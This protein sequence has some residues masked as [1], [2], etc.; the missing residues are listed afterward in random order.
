MRGTQIV[1][2]ECF[3][4]RKAQPR[5]REG[6]LRVP[7]HR[8]LEHLDRGEI[9]LRT[10]GSVREGVAAQVIVVC[11][12]AL[13]RKNT[14]VAL[15]A[16]LQHYVQLVHDPLRDTREEGEELGHVHVLVHDGGPH[17]GLVVRIDKLRPYA[18]SPRST[19][20][21]L[22]AHGPLEHVVRAAL[23]AHLSGSLGAPLVAQ[24]RLAPNDT[25]S[26]HHRESGGDLISDSLDEIR[27]LRCAEILKRQDKDARSS[28]R[29][30]LP[31]TVHH[32]A[33]PDR[34]QEHGDRQDARE[35]TPPVRP[36][37]DSLRRKLRLGQGAGRKSC[38]RRRRVLADRL[39][40]G[41]GLTGR[42]QLVLLREP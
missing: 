38:P 7:L 42:L 39:R 2:P 8:S 27:I 35:H 28:G 23:V 25:Q 22:P 26:L 30:R 14:E 4:V 33:D 16:W 41:S 11:L 1:Q 9:A 17:L 19:P 10:P 12:Q 24:R 37:F 18:H 20:R 3:G 40:Q 5:V 31:A 6:E 29:A 36:W 13:R 21:T 32:D 15:L 34:A